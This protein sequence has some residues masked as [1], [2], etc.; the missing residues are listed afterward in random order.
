VSRPRTARLLALAVLAGIAVATLTPGSPTRG[1]WSIGWP[2]TADIAVNLLLFLP[3]GLAL[4]HL[5]VRPLQVLVLATLLSAG[6]ELTQ[7][8]VVPGRSASPWDLAANVLGA[9]AGATAPGL[10]LA[11]PLAAAW[12]VSGPLLAPVA[13]PSEQWWGQWAHPFAGTTPFPGQ[14]LDV[15]F[16]QVPTAD[17]ELSRSETA[18]MRAGFSPPELIFHVELRT[19]RPA[20]GRSHLASIADG[21]GGAVIA[22]WQRGSALETTWHARGTALGLRSPAVRADDLLAVPDS[23]AASLATWIGDGHWFTVA[24]GAFYDRRAGLVLGPWQ[25]WRLLWPLAPPGEW[26]AWLLSLVWTGACLA[27]LGVLLV[28]SG[29]SRRR[30]RGA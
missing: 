24:E 9:T 27:P 18:A 26:L 30:R 12:L 4:R 25:G 16:N 8:L 22:F 29:M 20:S 2:S 14:I 3:L 7:F 17:V 11:L 23:V 5:G 13:P 19:G 15:R 21:Q 6:I 28:S 1:G 10:A